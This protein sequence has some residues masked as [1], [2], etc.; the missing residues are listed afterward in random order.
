MERERGLLLRRTSPLAAV[1]VLLAPA[2]GHAS[3]FSPDP[4]PAA[5]GLR[6]D[7]APEAATAAAVAQPLHAVVR[8]A[9]P[10]PVRA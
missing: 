2:T 8:T 7:P 5:N 6:P 3:S 9:P 1:L 10:A 4:P